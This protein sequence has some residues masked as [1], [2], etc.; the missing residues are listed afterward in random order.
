[1]RENDLKKHPSLKKMLLKIAQSL[2]FYL[3]DGES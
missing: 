1:M 2:K 3:Q